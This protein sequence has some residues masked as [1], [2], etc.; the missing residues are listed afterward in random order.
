MNIKTKKN[1]FF[2]NP[3]IHCNLVQVPQFF[4][5]GW[6][7]GGELGETIKINLVAPLLC[8]NLSRHFEHDLIQDQ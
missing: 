5:G 1:F 3:T 4:Y 8:L 2:G 6:G 7:G